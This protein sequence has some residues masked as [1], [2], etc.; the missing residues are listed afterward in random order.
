MIW[1]GKLKIPQIEGLIS[2]EDVEFSNYFAHLHQC[3]VLEVA[4]A[5]WLFMRLLM[6]NFLSGGHLK[7]VISKQPSILELPHGN[8]GTL[9]NT[10]FLKSIKKQMSYNHRFMTMEIPGVQALTLAVHVEVESGFPLPYKQ[11]NLCWELLLL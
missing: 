9:T 8:V 4:D 6:E 1:H 10:R 2:R 5:D 11:R 7:C 3:N